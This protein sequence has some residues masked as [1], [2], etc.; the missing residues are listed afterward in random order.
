MRLNRVVTAVV[1]AFVMVAATGC[2]DRQDAADPGTNL[3]QVTHGSSR[4]TPGKAAREICEPMVREAVEFEVGSPLSQ[5]PKPAVVDDTFTCLYEFADG[6]IDMS[7]RDLRERPDA[8]SYFGQLRT[9]A[10]T[11][12]LL[13]GLGDDAFLRQDATLVLIKDAMV[14]TIDM[15]GLPA[16]TPGGRDKP[17]ISS[18][19]GATVMGCW[20]GA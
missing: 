11:V 8:R 2:G 5:V 19:L 1:T 6:A 16:V 13:P 4:G 9:S 15:T 18:D 17:S 7:V 10:G 14:L 12:E 20:V 3:D